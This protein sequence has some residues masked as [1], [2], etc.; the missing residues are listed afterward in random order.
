MKQGNKMWEEKKSLNLT[1]LHMELERNTPVT[2]LSSLSRSLPVITAPMTSQLVQTPLGKQWAG[3][4]SVFYGSSK[5]QC[6]VILK[7]G[8][9]LIAKQ[10]SSGECSE[11]KHE[12]HEWISLL[13]LSATFGSATAFHL[14]ASP[15]RSKLLGTEFNMFES[16]VLFIW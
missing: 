16:E 3:G 10:A 11:N 4:M 6:R 2:I 12:R 13:Q 9:V 15:S 1:S 7:A 5:N 8:R 14:C